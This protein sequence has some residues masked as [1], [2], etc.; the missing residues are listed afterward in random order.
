MGRDGNC[1]IDRGRREIEQAARVSTLG[2][3]IIRFMGV[4]GNV[5]A[6]LISLF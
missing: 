1:W 6:N 3:R 2:F 4:T 5:K